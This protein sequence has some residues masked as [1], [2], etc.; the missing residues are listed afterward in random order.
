MNKIFLKAFRAAHLNKYSLHD[1]LTTFLRTYRN[2]P[3]STTGFTP[4]KLLLGRE[5]KTKLP[6]LEEGVSKDVR[7]AATKMHNA[8][9]KMKSDAD[10][11]RRAS[12]SNLVVGD[13]VLIK[14]I[15]SHKLMTTFCKEPLKVIAKKGNCIVMRRKDG[16]VVKRNIS[17]VKKVK[18]GMK[19]ENYK[20]TCAKYDSDESTDDECYTAPNAVVGNNVATDTNAT[21]TKNCA[22]ATGQIVDRPKRIINKPAYLQDY[23]SKRKEEM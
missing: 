2:T 20:Y 19:V 11:S 9:N 14:Q 15:K 10:K 16:V 13:A 5:V 3:H 12:E 8:Q 1:A 4:S 6:L 18:Q 22:E 21:P 23:V 7:Q 17:H